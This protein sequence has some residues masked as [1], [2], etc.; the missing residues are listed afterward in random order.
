MATVT[1]VS[2]EH[3]KVHLGSEANSEVTVEVHMSRATAMKLAELETA[4][5]ARLNPKRADL[6]RWSPGVA[7]LNILGLYAANGRIT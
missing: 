4:R 1:Q 2:P 7:V 5:V 6:P 3:W